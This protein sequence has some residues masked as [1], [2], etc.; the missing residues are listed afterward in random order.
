MSTTTKRPVRVYMNKNVPGTRNWERV[1][2]HERG[3][4]HQFSIESE[5]LDVGA[6]HCPVAVVELPDGTVITPATHMIQFLDTQGWEGAA[7]G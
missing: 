2:Q 4:F 1:V 6:S 3:Y 5:E 7:H